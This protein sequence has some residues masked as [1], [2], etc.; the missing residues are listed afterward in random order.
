MHDPPDFEKMAQ[1]Y[2]ILGRNYKFSG[3]LEMAIS[4]YS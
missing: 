4:C 1:L 3:K 2:H